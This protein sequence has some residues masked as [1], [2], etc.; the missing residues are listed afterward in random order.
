MLTDIDRPEVLANLRRNRDANFLSTCLTANPVCMVEALNWG[1]IAAAACVADILELSFKAARRGD[2]LYRVIEGNICHHATF[3]SAFS[4]SIVKDHNDDDIGSGGGGIGSMKLEYI[5]SGDGGD[6]RG[7]GGEISSGPGLLLLAADCLYDAA[8]YDA[9]FA[10]TSYLLRRFAPPLAPSPAALD[11]ASTP[12]LMA[13]PRGSRAGAGGAQ[14]ELLAVFHERGAGFSLAARARRWGL[15]CQ[16]LPPPPPTHAAPAARRE[17]SSGG[18]DAAD[19][20]LL[21]FRLA[22]AAGLPPSTQGCQ[23][24]AGGGSCS[25][26]L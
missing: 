18:G 22:H 16:E 25:G 5:R 9:F 12:G 13:Q 14:C 2:D 20:H 7:G 6:A 10:T 19:L 11:V 4:S 15:R 26:P 23:A 21:S 17:A 8:L 3:T 24:V 1:D